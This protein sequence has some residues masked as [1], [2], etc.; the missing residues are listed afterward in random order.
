[1]RDGSVGEHTSMCVLLGGSSGQCGDGALDLLKMVSDS[2]DS[3]IIISTDWWSVKCFLGGSDDTPSRRSSA[4]A[5]FKGSE[6]G[7]DSISK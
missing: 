3:G 5:A 1:M 6:V 2:D 7:A 4:F